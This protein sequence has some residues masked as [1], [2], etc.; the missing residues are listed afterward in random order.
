MSA[1]DTI[2]KARI[3]DGEREHP[4]LFPMTEYSRPPLSADALCKKIGL[5]WMSAVSLHEQGWLSFDPS[6]TEDL[7]PSQEAE[8][9]FLGALVVAGCDS[10]VLKQLL[11]RLPKPYAYRADRIYFD[12]GN[13]T[14]RLLEDADDLEDKFDAWVQEMIGWQE[15]DRLERLRQ[16]VENAISILHDRRESRVG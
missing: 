8:L 13:R 3:R 9:S 7:T 4:T 10:G 5:N 1:P 16:Q 12:W 6:E 15:M 2:E 14:W 11:S